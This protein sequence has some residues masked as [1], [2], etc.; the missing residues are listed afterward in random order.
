V[1]LLYNYLINSNEEDRNDQRLFYKNMVLMNCLDSYGNPGDQSHYP[2]P[3]K[4]HFSSRLERLRKNEL[5]N[6]WDLVDGVWVK[7]VDELDKLVILPHYII[8]WISKYNYYSTSD[9]HGLASDYM[10]DDLYKHIV[11]INNGCEWG[12]KNSRLTRRMELAIGEDCPRFYDLREKLMVE[13]RIIGE[14]KYL[15]SREKYID[16]PTEYNE[17]DSIYD[18]RDVY[19]SMRQKIL[20]L[21]TSP[22]NEIEYDYENY[23]NYKESM[24]NQW[25]IFVDQYGDSSFL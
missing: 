12:I 15:V 11:P 23:S 4:S 21:N 9:D 13:I 20:Y 1:K 6:K 24:P 19:C 14:E 10:K 17:E 22:W 8:S 5:C 3:T 16:C 7:N 2:G 18:E 25:R